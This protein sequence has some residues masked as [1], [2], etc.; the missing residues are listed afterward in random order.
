VTHSSD[1]RQ[2]RRPLLVAIVVFKFAKGLLLLSAGIALLRF[3]QQPVARFLLRE[4]NWA[5][6]YPRL[7]LTARFLRELSRTFE[8]HFSAIVAAC[9]IGG[10]FLAAEGICLW[11]GYTWAPWFAIVL[12][13]VWLPFEAR[14]LIFRASLHGFALFAVNLLIVLYLYR[15]RKEF[16][17]HV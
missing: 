3:R 7:A 17:R 12:T 8:L 6:D 4:A 16:H 11:L 15:H 5:D 10:A 9:F 13:A 14:E 2:A 1:N